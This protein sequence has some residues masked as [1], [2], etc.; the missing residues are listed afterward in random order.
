MPANSSCSAGFPCAL[1]PPNCLCQSMILEMKIGRIKE[2]QKVRLKDT[3]EGWGKAEEKQNCPQ[4]WML[5]PSLG[6][7]LFSCVRAGNENYCQQVAVV[8]F[9]LPSH[10]GCGLREIR[11]PRLYPDL[12]N[13]IPVLTRSPG[14]LCAHES[15]RRA[16]GQGFFF[17]LSAD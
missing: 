5:Y 10:S 11:T 3:A 2:K 17:Q 15:L 16:P 12:Q 14:E 6:L 9:G 8:L 1:L 4:S 13:Q 7:P